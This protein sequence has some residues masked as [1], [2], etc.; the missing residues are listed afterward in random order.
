MWGIENFFSLPIL[1]S[2]SSSGDGG[3]PHV[4]EFPDSLISQKMITIA[5]SVIGE[6][7][8]LNNDSSSGVSYNDNE[9]MIILNNTSG[10]R[11]SGGGG[12][13]INSATVRRACKC[14]LCVEEL[15]GR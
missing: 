6:I 7:N 10:G 1:S 12:V 13:G 4:I 3:K 11:G 8:K 15:S 2:V 14:A 9:N 5:E